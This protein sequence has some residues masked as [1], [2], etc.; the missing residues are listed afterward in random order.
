MCGE[1]ENAL[2]GYEPVSYTQ[3]YSNDIL[4]CEVVF[5]LGVHNKRGEQIK[6]TRISIECN[7]IVKCLEFI[8]DNDK[9]LGLDNSFIDNNDIINKDIKIDVKKG[10]DLENDI[11][12]LKLYTDLST[13]IRE[14]IEEE[15]K[16]NDG[17]EYIDV[18]SVFGFDDI[19]EEIERLQ[20]E[21][22][23]NDCE[24]CILQDEE[25]NKIKNKYQKKIDKLTKEIDNYK[26]S[27][28][29]LYK[30]FLGK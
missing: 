7:K 21:E 3:I 13:G 20:K 10:E 8:N 26:Q 6:P 17:N 4:G 29:K 19:L 5:S 24:K 16:E 18:E 28:D 12:M 14:L 23:S 15:E 9:C 11:D 1:K 2:N 27:M 25:I 22:K 30:L